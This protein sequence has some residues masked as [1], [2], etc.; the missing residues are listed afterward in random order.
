VPSR[1]LLALV[2][3]ALLGLATVAGALARLAGDERTSP[4]STSTLEATFVDR[5]GDGSLERGPGEPL[6]VRT[7]LA[8][9]APPGEELAVFAQITD[10]HVVDEESPARVEMLDRLGAPFTSAFRCVL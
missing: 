7:E 2:A 3:A 4:D 9:A 10:A 5:D 8:P 6:L 1:R